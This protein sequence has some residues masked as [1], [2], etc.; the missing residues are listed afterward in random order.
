MTPSEWGLLSDGRA[1]HQEAQT[2]RIAQWMS[3]LLSATCGQPIS[4]A[5]LLGEEEAADSPRQKAA[6]LR[7]AEKRFQTM[8][9]RIAKNNAKGI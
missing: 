6:D 3:P 2:R 4:P 5:Q 9:R 8:Q 7:A 1:A